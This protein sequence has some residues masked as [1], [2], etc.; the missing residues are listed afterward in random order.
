MAL[1]NLGFLTVLHESSGYLGGY[2]VTNVWGRPLEFRLTSA[3]QPNRVQHILYA[4][5]L[6]PYIC[7]DLIGKTL[8]D[9]AAVPVQLLL[10][11]RASVLDLR[12]KLECP[13]VWL[14]AADDA[15]AAALT[16]RMAAP[17]QAGHG[18][19]LCHPRFPDDVA[20]TRELLGH[21]DVGFDLAE[22]FVRIREA[23]S[24]ARKMG[25][26]K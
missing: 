10:T 19:L 6:E 7:A 21:L 5:T 16:E 12:L 9:K 4:S 1:T 2:L 18:P 17:A 22:P 25:V 26:H 15:Q 13:V 3:V 23:I 8:V 20:R 24:E 14:A 11:D